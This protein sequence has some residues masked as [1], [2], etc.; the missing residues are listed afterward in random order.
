[1][2]QRSSALTPK[3]PAERVVRDIRRAT[4][5]HGTRHRLGGRE[6]TPPAGTDP[7]GACQSMRR[8]LT[9]FGRKDGWA[10]VP[11]LG[12]RNFTSFVSFGFKTTFWLLES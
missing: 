9:T 12:V 8:D 6:S 3:P 7:P 10:I 4:R 5:R 1:M 2:S 11:Q